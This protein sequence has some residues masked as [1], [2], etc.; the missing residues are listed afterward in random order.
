MANHTAI[1]RTVEVKVLQEIEFKVIGNAFGLMIA[2]GGLLAGT[3]VTHRSVEYWQE[4]VVPLALVVIM[5][6]RL[7]RS[8]IATMSAYEVA[9]NRT[10]QNVHRENVQSDNAFVAQ[11]AAPA[12]KSYSAEEVMDA[13]AKRIE[14]QKE[15]A[16]KKNK[17]SN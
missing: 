2:A 1:N 11:L 14:A 10:H 15:E 17:F 5:A 16:L 4:D 3:M 12:P 7:I 13:V 6:V 8:F 9:P